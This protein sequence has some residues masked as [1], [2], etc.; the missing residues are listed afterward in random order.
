LGN[1]TLLPLLEGLALH[2]V[3]QSPV[4]NKAL[5]QLQEAMQAYNFKIMERK[6][7][8]MPADFSSSTLINAIS[9]DP[10]QLEKDQEANLIIGHHR[11]FLLHQELP[12]G[13]HLHTLI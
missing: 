3:H 7:A 1:G 2:I 6:D 13:N 12:H 9:W 4:H 11:K 8:E 5:N 10:K